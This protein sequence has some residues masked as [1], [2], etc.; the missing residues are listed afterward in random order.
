MELKELWEEFKRYFYYGTLFIATYTLISDYTFLST[1]IN[2][3]SAMCQA[4]TNN[5][6]INNIIPWEDAN[7]SRW[8]STSLFRYKFKSSNYDDYIIVIPDVNMTIYNLDYFTVNY[9]SYQSSFGLDHFNSYSGI[10]GTATINNTNM[11]IPL[12]I[13]VATANNNSFS[14]HTS[15]LI[16]REGYKSPKSICRAS[17][18][19]CYVN[20]VINFPLNKIDI[21][22]SSTDNSVEFYDFD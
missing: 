13:P 5:T 9:G 4:F 19:N 10:V 12:V 11:S 6:L 1:L 7:L 17:I 3:T 21:N 14:K 8:N 15:Y 2:S 18:P 20:D 16:I 22:T